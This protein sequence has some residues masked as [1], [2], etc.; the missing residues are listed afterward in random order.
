MCPEEH[1]VQLSRT[2]VHLH[3]SLA[4]GCPL[5]HNPDASTSSPACT[6]W[7]DPFR[8][9]KDTGQ[10]CGVARSCPARL[11][12]AAVGI[13]GG[14]QQCLRSISVHVGGSPHSLDLPSR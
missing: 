11:H 7:E 10:G 4:E 3:P 9:E 2:A 12:T 1:T 14:Y 8:S 13:Q 5:G 6:I